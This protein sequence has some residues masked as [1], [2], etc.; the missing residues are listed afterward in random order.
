MNR[1]EAIEVIRTVKSSQPWTAQHDM[2]CRAS[3]LDPDNYRAN[4]S[5][6]WPESMRGKS[7]VDGV[8]ILDHMAKI[9]KLATGGLTR[10]MQ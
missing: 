7:M 4:F 6:G 10:S 9:E 1:D 5:E 8:E 3:G 2:A